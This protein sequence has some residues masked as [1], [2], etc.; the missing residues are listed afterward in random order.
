MVTNHTNLDRDVVH[1]ARHAK[2]VVRRM[3]LTLY[4]NP[5]KIWGGESLQVQNSN[6][7]KT[8]QDCI[9]R[10][11]LYFNELGDPV[12]ANMVSLQGLPK[13]YFQLFSIS[14]K[15]KASLD[16]KI[17]QRLHTGGDINCMNDKGSEH[18]PQKCSRN[19]QKY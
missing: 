7:L 14:L 18:F 15:P 9:A 3:T 8:L 1:M 17:L 16:S 10:S 11:P 4:A 2:D 12:F 5:R 19:L 13:K 6:E